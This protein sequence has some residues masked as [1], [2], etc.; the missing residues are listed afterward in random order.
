M[1]VV[2]S[3]RCLRSSYKITENNLERGF[4]FFNYIT[5][6]FIITLNIT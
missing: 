2:D 3:S 5:N 6:I 1:E 4:S